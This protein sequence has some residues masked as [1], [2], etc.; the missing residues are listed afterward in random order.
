MAAQLVTKSGG[1]VH[2]YKG[3]G[4]YS[5]GTVRLST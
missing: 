5:K 1:A 3:S 2:T 4:D